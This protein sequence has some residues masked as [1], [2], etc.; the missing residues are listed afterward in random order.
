MIN[1]SEVLPNPFQSVGPMLPA[2]PCS[3]KAPASDTGP[4]GGDISSQATL[5]RVI[6]SI[7]ADLQA[8]VDDLN[9]AEP[10]PLFLKSEFLQGSRHG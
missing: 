8:F 6:L 4:D 9:E 3:P 10:L 5:A 7:E 2:E 1:H